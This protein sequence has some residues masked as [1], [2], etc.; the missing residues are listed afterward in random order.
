MSLLDPASALARA[1]AADRSGINARVAEARRIRPLLDTAALGSWLC[2]PVAALA[3]NLAGDLTAFTEAAIDVSLQLAAHGLLSGPARLSYEKL[4]TAVLPSCLR[5]LSEEPRETLALL[6]NAS[7]NMRQAGSDILGNWL[8]ALEAL[9]PLARNTAELRGLCSLLAWKSGLPQYRESALRLAGTLPPALT[10]AALGIPKNKDCESTLE[11]LS[12]DRWYD[13]VRGAPIA[14]RVAHRI[15][16]FSGFGGTF[17]SPPEVRADGELFVVKSGERYFRLYA[18]T[19]GAILQ[20]ASPADY[21]EA[22]N[23]KTPERRS[24]KLEKSDLCCGAERLKI[25]LPE[26]GL[27]FACGSDTLAVYSQWSYSILILPLSRGK[28][29]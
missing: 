28:A 17:T 6:H 3:E 25:D 2:G 23:E 16:A 13:P 11:R 4:W 15:G 10:A 8:S 18:D 21:A 24:V 12:A 29:E 19:R 22:E 9:S 27:A 5:P 14:L 1:L 26:D 20:A 7:L